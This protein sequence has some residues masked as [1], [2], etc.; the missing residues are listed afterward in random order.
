MIQ[1]RLQGLQLTQSKVQAGGMQLAEAAAPGPLYQADCFRLATLAFTTGWRRLTSVLGG[2]P[3]CPGWLSIAAGR[4][5][6]ASVGL[7]Y[8]LGLAR[9]GTALLSPCWVTPC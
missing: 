9:P 5:E 1:D 4:E 6:R 8:L 7:L 3:T 2:I